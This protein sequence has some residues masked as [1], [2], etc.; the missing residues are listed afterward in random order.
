MMRYY[1]FGMMG[2][3]LGWIF[4]IFLVALVIIGVIIFIKSNRKGPQFNNGMHTN[5]IEILNQRYARGEIT[6]EEYIKKKAEI[7]KTLG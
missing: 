2:Y 7:L 6:D 3:G 4:T 1:G 5:A